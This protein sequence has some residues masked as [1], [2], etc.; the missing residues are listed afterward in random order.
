VNFPF[1]CSACGTVMLTAEVMVGAHVVC[2]HCD[3]PLEVPPLQVSPQQQRLSGQDL[4][5]GKDG[6]PTA[7][8]ASFSFGG[9]RGQA[10]AEMDMTPMVDVTFLLL[11]FFMVTA[12]FTLQKSF[13]VPAPR[14]DQPS[15][16]TRTTE[17]FQEDPHFVVVRVD[18]SNTIHVSTAGWNNEI[19]T[20]TKPDL[21]A[22]LR[23]AR[24]TR[25]DGI[26]P[27]RML[28]LANGEAQHEHVVTALDAGA[29]V[30]MEEVK[31]VTVEEDF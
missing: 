14:N 22:R 16:E 31:L 19:E 6:I 10:D 25:Q 20:P 21:L 7:D 3:T 1:R 13:E 12:S 4:R 30:G 11:I 8:E 18:A 17:D 27:T 24:E 5:Q 15:T 28:V 29:A 26:V 23:E 2:V 9:D